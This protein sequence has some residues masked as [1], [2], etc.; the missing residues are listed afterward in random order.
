ML[1]LEKMRRQVQLGLLIAAVVVL[2]AV[3]VTFSVLV[4]NQTRSEYEDVSVSG[5]IETDQVWGAKVYVTGETHIN[6]GVRV[7]ILPEAEIILSDDD[8]E[9]PAEGD[10]IACSMLI[11]DSGSAVT[12]DR[13]LVRGA[14]CVSGLNCT[15]TANNGG[16]Y[17]NSYGGEELPPS[18]YPSIVRSTESSVISIRSFEGWGLGGCKKA[19]LSAVTIVGCG[20]GGFGCGF[21][22]I[23]INSPGV[24]GAF[25]AYSDIALSSLRITTDRPR[26]VDV[27][28]G[29]IYINE[30]LV[31]ESST[32]FPI[33]TRAGGEV[34][35]LSGAWMNIT[36]VG[37]V[38]CSDT[39]TDTALTSPVSVRLEDTFTF[40]YQPSSSVR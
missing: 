30:A 19:A 28:N 15:G 36:S 8:I 25:S 21:H 13:M 2:S 31:V 24:G 22:D 16:V 39:V 27:L 11:F 17:F 38:A 14:N 6:P 20:Y 34:V 26:S 37:A 33:C 12:A 3:I 1:G 9:A 32:A 5:R 4:W 23:T 29:N 40:K 10:S 7:T 35:V 18:A